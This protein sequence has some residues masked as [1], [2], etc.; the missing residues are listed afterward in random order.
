MDI[1]KFLSSIELFESL[2]SQIIKELADTLESI[3]IPGG[4]TFIRQGD[5]ADCLYI[6]LHGRLSA[7][8]TINSKTIFLGE[9]G[10]GEVVGEV[11]IL[12]KE[13]RMATVQTIRDSTLLKFTQE[14]FRAI[15]L[16]HPDMLLEFTKKSMARLLQKKPEGGHSSLKTLVLVPSGSSPIP[17]NFIVQFIEALALRGKVLHLTS[18]SSNSLPSSEWLTEQESQYRYVVYEV[19]QSLTPWTLLS[20][21]QADRILF[22]GV[23]HRVSSLN[24]VEAFIFKEKKTRASEFILLHEQSSSLLSHTQ[25]WLNLRPCTRHHHVNISCNNDFSRLIRFIC[26]ESIGLVLSGGGARALAHL[27]LIRALEELKIPIDYIGG[28]SMGGTIA[29]AIALGM[30]YKTM[31]KQVKE[32]VVPAV[33]AWDYTLP[34]LSLKSCKRLTAACKQVLGREVFIED[35]PISFFCVSTNLSLRRMEI[36]QKGLLWKAVRAS[37]SIPAILPPV[38]D[39]EGNL[40][41]DGGIVNNLPVDVMRS[42]INGG[43][44]IA[45]S[46]TPTPKVHY[47]SLPSAIS[48]WDLL[49]NKI[50]YPKNKIPHMTD[51]LLTSLML[52]SEHH[53]IEME[54][55][56]DFCV[57]FSLPDVSLMDFKHFQ[58]II[59]QGYEAS[60]EQLKHFHFK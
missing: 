4:S 1:V 42:V 34:L 35:C 18:T 49:K 50:K 31:V 45:S 2:P 25:S 15:T 56:A 23:D 44:I 27:G 10:I 17:Q 53:Q 38:T 12:T 48:G 54:N 29:G 37:F 41:V 46:I 60:L 20:L 51:V 52:G 9:I 28:S 36:H 6:L 13:K 8:Q 58:K 22:I 43:R 3:Y 7:Y 21:R 5:E 24:E 57:K 59:D 39:E 40:Y 14:H 11:A 16:K 32:Y 55:A 47:L 19:D 26:G 33:T 30:D